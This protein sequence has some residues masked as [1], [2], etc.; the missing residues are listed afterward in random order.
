M[1]RTVHRRLLLP[2]HRHGH[3]ALADHLAV[4]ISGRAASSSASFFCIDPFNAWSGDDSL[5]ARQAER[6]VRAADEPPHRRFHLRRSVGILELLGSSK[7]IYTVPILGDIKIFEMPV[8]GYFGFPPF[9]LECFTM[10]VFVRRLFW[11]RPAG[12]SASERSPTTDPDH[13][14]HGHRPWP[15]T[16]YRMRVYGS[17]PRARD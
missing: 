14:P 3:A 4:S 6:V 10:Y 17:H 8:L 13:R 9:A 1:R 2:L 5:L 12:R 7:W 15:D 11:H 16:T